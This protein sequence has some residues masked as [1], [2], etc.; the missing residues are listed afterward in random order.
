MISTKVRDW[1]LS[2]KINLVVVWESEWETNPDK[3]INYIDNII[4]YRGK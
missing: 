1:Y 3:V 2:T 4:C